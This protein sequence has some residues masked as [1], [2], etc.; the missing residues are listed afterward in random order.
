ML[1][2][3]YLALR[4]EEIATLT[5]EAF[6][7][8]MEWVTILGKGHR[9]RHLPVHPT[10]QTELAPRRSGGYLFPAIR[11]GGL[12]VHCATVRRWVGQVGEE[13]GVGFLNPHALRHTCL[14][15]LNDETGDLRITQYF[16]GHSNPETTARYTRATQKRLLAAVAAIRYA[17]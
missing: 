15:T 7:R 12:Y 17:A 6:D 16:A 11:G 5:W 8:D 3:L 10:L 9:T 4:R 13:A 1:L 2:G 14:A